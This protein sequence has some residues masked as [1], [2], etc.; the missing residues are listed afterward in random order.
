MLHGPCSWSGSSIVLWRS[1]R[2]ISLAQELLTL[3]VMG[4]PQSFIS[5]VSALIRLARQSDPGDRPVAPA[6][7][8]PPVRDRLVPF[9]SLLAILVV[10][11][12]VLLP[13]RH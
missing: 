3:R 11:L 5:P 12:A 4:I 9:L 7:V 10:A 1:R 8:G 13:C 6:S 2:W